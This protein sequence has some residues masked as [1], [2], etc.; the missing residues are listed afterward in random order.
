MTCAVQWLQ[1]VRSGWAADAHESD[2]KDNCGFTA[3]AM[4]VRENGQAGR[5][6]S[7]TGKHI[8]TGPQ[9]GR[10]ELQT[11][12]REVQEQWY[13]R[14]SRYCLKG[15]RVEKESGKQ[16]IPIRVAAVA[17]QPDQQY[18]C[19]EL[20]LMERWERAHM[21]LSQ[22]NSA[23]LCRNFTWTETISASVHE[24]CGFILKHAE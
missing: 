10:A 8:S 14:L 20:R 17:V 16:L 6:A 22:H 4:A 21:G 1:R 9:L 23:I 18:F 11:N 2:C 24:G 13:I 19:F 15:R 5:L 12:C 3:L 7:K